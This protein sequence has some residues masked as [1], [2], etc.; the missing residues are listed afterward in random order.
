MTFDNTD[1]KT[2]QA[3]YLYIQNRKI[4]VMEKCL[5]DILLVCADEQNYRIGKIIEGTLKDLTN[6]NSELKE[7]FG[8]NKDV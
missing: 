2:K 8:K 4:T 3:K 7:L 1:N 5:E 6:L